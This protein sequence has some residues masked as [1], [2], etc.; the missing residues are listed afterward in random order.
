MF[1]KNLRSAP[2]FSSRGWI[3]WKDPNPA[4]GW[5]REGTVRTEKPNSADPREGP[6]SHF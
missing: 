3:S 2:E 5:Q 1:A 4:A 6:K